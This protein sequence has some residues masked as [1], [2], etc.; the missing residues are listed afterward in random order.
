MAAAD[1]AEE[2]GTH[3]SHQLGYEFVLISYF[4]HVLTI[5]QSGHQ[6]R[7]P[8]PTDGRLS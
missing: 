2:Y 3:L 8:G 1:T 7:N 6:P 4:I 5:A